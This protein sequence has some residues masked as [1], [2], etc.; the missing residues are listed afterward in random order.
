MS[1]KYNHD[2]RL[3]TDLL[4]PTVLQ[5][6]HQTGGGGGGERERENQYN[7]QSVRFQQQTVCVS[8]EAHTVYV[9]ISKWDQVQLRQDLNNEEHYPQ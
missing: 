2:H 3:T 8:V 6:L 9:T 4:F 5:P 1:H 7:G